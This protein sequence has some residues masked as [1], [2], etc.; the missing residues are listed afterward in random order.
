MRNKANLKEKKF[1]S[2][3]KRSLSYQ[4][5]AYLSIDKLNMRMQA[6]I[7]VLIPNKQLNQIHLKIYL[8]K[9]ILK[10]EVKYQM[11]RK[12]IIFLKNI[13]EVI[14]ITIRASLINKPLTLSK[15]Y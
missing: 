2:Y 12:L 11:L 6:K 9:A 3:S 14:I 4:V 13:W 5:T 10:L 7:R 8:N 15:M 1:N